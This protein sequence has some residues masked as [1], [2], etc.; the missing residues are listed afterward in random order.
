MAAIQ[1]GQILESTLDTSV[2]R[3]IRFLE[4]AGTNEERR[5]EESSGTSAECGT[6]IRQV[7]AESI[8]LLKND[9]LILPL[10]VGQIDSIAVIGSLATDRV[11]SHL[12]SPSYMITPLE[13]I[14]SFL[15]SLSS[16]SECKIAHAHG[17]QT[18]RLVPCL[19]KRFT[20]K[21]EVRLWNMGDRT[22]RAGAKPVHIESRKEAI[23]TFLMRKVPGLM[24]DFEI[25]M[26]ATVDIPV[27][28]DYEVGV[29]SASNA[30]VYI[31]DVE[32]YDFVPDGVVDVQ[33]FLFHQHTFEQR[34]RHHF[35]K[36]G[37]YVLRCISQ[38]QKQ[39]GQE[40]VATGLFL[41]M[42]ECAT[43]EA[44]IEEAVQL[45]TESD[46]AVV[47]VGTTS[48]WEMEGVDRVNLQLPS[49]QDD[50]VRAVIAAK[51]GDKVIVV[52]Q[53][54]AA[55]DLK[56]ADGAGAIVHAHFGG[57]E[58][59][60]G[61]QRGA[62]RS[63]QKIVLT[64]LDPRRLQPSPTFSLGSPRLRAR[65]LTRGRADWRI[66]HR[67]EIS[68]TTTSSSWH[69]PRAC[70]WGG[71]DTKGR[72]RPSQHTVG[73]STMR[74]VFYLVDKR[75][76]LTCRSSSRPVFGHGL[77][78]TTFA[79]SDVR[80]EGFVVDNTKATLQIKVT[81][82]GC[83]EGREVVQVYVSGPGSSKIER[84]AKSLEGFA[85]T[86]HLQ[87]GQSETIAIDLGRRSFAYWSTEQDVWVV[88]PGSYMVHVAKSSLD[89]VA[90]KELVFDT[91]QRWVG[92]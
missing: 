89:I 74:L 72:E 78:Y 10:D 42:V 31:D 16:P 67:L 43:K 27:A 5:K 50:L 73:G 84:P 14:Q 92:L 13:G 37:K 40:P 81:N 63:S 9:K 30:K 59:G 83:R 17:P 38:S 4:R 41:G 91:E 68:L 28:G 88:E 11:I 65:R 58:A 21:I 79:Y 45:A 55:V 56:C 46:V 18:H 71:K 36:A 69:M 1:S 87:P 8:I 15:S 26:V 54:G 66:V 34:Y 53:S 7:A 52:N 85:K 29:I 2:K 57:Q 47:F 25:E 82:T 86:T 62:G 32:V 75:G 90:S 19:D 44:R 60:N 49:G 24:E 48:E 33:R 6:L 12:I 77:S 76:A 22:S 20:S 39:V 23:E 3:M 51:G 61:E 35:A 64:R 70:S 80:L